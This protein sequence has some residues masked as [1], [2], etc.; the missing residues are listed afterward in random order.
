MIS[1]RDRTEPEQRVLRA[2]GTGALVDLRTGDKDLDD[3]ARGATW[4]ADRTVRA[5]LLVELL[6][7]RW[8]PKT[9][10]LRSVRLAGVRIVGSLD[11]ESVTLGCPL[12]LENCYLDEHLNLLRAKAPAVSL[13]GCR[14]PSIDGRGFQAHGDVALGHSLCSRVSLLGARVGG[15]LYLSGTTLTNPRGDAL[16]A[17]EL[18]VEQSMFC[19]NGFSATGKVRLNGARVGGHLDLGTATLSNPRGRALE[20]TQLVVERG[21]SCRRLSAAGEVLLSGARIGGELDLGGAHLV[22]EGGCALVADRLTVEGNMFCGGGF[23]AEGEVRLIGAQ[24]GASLEF[25]GASLVNPEGRALN[26]DYVTVRDD[27]VCGNGFSAK[28]EVRLPYANVGGWVRFSGAHLTNPKRWALAADQIIVKQSMACSEGF[29]AEGEVRLTGAHIGE[30]L[31]F[32]DASLSNAEGLALNAERLTVGKDLFCRDGFSATG[33]V[34]LAGTQIGGHIDLSGAKLTGSDGVA[35][36]LVGTR[37]DTLLLLPDGRPNG[38]V[39]LTGARVGSLFDDETTWPA[40]LALDG[41]VYES[42]DNDAVG[43]RARLGWLARNRGGYTPQT[44]EQLAAA[45]R[46]AGREEAARRV[47]ITKQWHRR[48]QLNP[49]GRAW[50][51]LLYLTVGYGYRTWLAAVWL[52]GLTVLGNLVFTNAFPAH[53]RPATGSAPAFNAVGYTLDVLLPIVDL[54]QQQAWQPQAAALYWSWALTGA[55]WVLTTAVVAGLT[56]VLRRE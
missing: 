23:S 7:G 21:M 20:A 31:A 22:N 24:V 44:Y 8:K 12:L 50:N 38:V 43:V 48:R 13:L 56:S 49:L 3:L 19:R 35:L 1:E 37:A 4:G 6:T 40:E 55:G 27:V 16:L 33:Q 10:P 34:R 32:V 18:T 51:W 45:Y 30:Q 17:D 5:E 47:A 36:V 39:D 54:G 52:A 25:R 42:L 15:Q 41:F 46:R 28:G 14:V 9:G 2:A 11:L 29:A 53:M 26:A